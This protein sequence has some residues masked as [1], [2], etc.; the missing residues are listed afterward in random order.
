MPE[1]KVI[2]ASGHGARES[3]L[4]A[5]ALGAYDF[6]QKPVDADELG[7]IV[8]RAFHVQALEAENR[9]LAEQ[10]QAG[11]PQGII[12]GRPTLLQVCEMIELVAP[13]AGA[14]VCFWVGGSGGEE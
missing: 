13:A 12:S 3:A 11:S 5:I 10:R 14:V 6:Y 8:K 9:V 4:R 1:T 7:F 2:V